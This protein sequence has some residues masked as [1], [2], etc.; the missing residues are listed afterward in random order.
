MG[1]QDDAYYALLVARLCHEI[2]SGV[3]TYKSCPFKEASQAEVQ[4][5]T[6]RPPPARFL[7]AAISPALY[8]TASPTSRPESAAA[9]R[10][11]LS[12]ADRE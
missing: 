3:F 7:K 11:A 2:K 12:S 4:R 1:V 6:T 5:V 9:C 8:H 10:R